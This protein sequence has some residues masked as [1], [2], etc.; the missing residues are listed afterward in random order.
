MLLTFR[1]RV[2]D[3][4]VGK[5]LTRMAVA[6]NQVW[7]YC[8][9]IQND[10]RR[11]NRRW[12]SGFDLIGLTNG[13]TK[14]LG[15]HSDTVQAVCKQ[16]ATSRDK[17]RRRPRWRASFG[18]KRSLGWVPFQCARP[19]RVS[20]DT[21]TFLGRKY[22]LWL[23]RPIPADIRSG[24]FSQD[25][26]GRWF[27]NLVCGVAADLPAGDG[28]VGIDLGLKDFAALSTGDKIANPRH[29]RRSAAKLARAQ[30]A[31]RKRLARKIHRKVAAR[32][33][34]FLH[35]Q[36]TRIVRANALICVGD[37]NSAALA[38]TRMAKSVLDAGWSAFRS[39]LQYKT[40]MRPG[41]RF[42]ETNERHSTRTCSVCFARSGPSGLKGL[43]VR[44]WVC[45]GCG[46]LHDRDTNSGQNIL[47]SG[48]N[49]ALQTT[50]IPAL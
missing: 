49:A 23:S 27:L 21:V 43:R 48:R 1:Y 14:E 42:V 10:S 9:G 12:P 30:R 47:R 32:R 20:D 19:L 31:G 35:E 34:H 17:A 24:S 25:A 37:V 18:A 22:R 2:K 39:M 36:S 6:V 33:R 3:A 4:T 5:R 26:D 8:G 44:S 38:R 7:N 11:L 50:E 45:D 46:T 40:A 28:E 13:C 41:A 29:L 15:L 16:F